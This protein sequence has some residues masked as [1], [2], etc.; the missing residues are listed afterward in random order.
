MHG[1]GRRFCN[2]LPRARAP[3]HRF[4][5]PDLRRGLA[6]EMWRTIKPGGWC[7]MFDFRYDNPRNPN[8]RK[9]TQAELRRYWP[10]AV[11][12][13]HLA[14]GAANRAPPGRRALPGHRTVGGDAAPAALAFHLYGAQ[15]Q[16]RAALLF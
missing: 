12:L 9:V 15:G 8:V 7:M 16:L 1:I 10:A 11:P 13:S 5:D 6:A 4:L 14:T 2:R 3:W